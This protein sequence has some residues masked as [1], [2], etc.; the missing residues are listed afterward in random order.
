VTVL[1]FFSYSNFGQR[2]V[3]VSLH[4]PCASDCTPGVEH[5]PN[6]VMGSNAE[7]NQQHVTITHDIVA[8]FHPV[9][10]GLTH[11]RNGTLFD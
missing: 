4:T 10:P 7:L 3:C 11:M 2:V 9:V 5:G 8:A 1:Q 6:G